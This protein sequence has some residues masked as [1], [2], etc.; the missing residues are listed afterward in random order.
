M[1][2]GFGLSEAERVSHWL[3]LFGELIMEG[4]D[5]RRTKKIERRSDESDQ[6]DR[7]YM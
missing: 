6:S 7:V 2:G 4:C 5:L 3:W 1:V